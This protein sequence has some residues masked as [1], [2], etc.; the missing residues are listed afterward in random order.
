MN[1]V[2]SNLITNFIILCPQLEWDL[3]VWNEKKAAN[4]LMYR[5]PRDLE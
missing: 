2:G 4:K 5:S 3:K 1:N